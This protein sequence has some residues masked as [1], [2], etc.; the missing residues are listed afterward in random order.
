VWLFAPTTDEL[1]AEAARFAG[2]APSKVFH[3]DLSDEWFGPPIRISWR[4]RLDQVTSEK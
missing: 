1:I 4:S 3:R 2:A